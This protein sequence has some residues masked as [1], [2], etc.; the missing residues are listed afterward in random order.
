MT[1]RCSVSGVSPTLA[2]CH[3]GYAYQGRGIIGGHN[4]AAYNLEQHEA[5]CLN[6]QARKESRRVI[7]VWKNAG[8][9]PP[10][11]GQFPLPYVEGVQEVVE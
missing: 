4:F 9:E 8:L 2:C 7:R 3:C 5:S 1:K 10:I 11:P 6:Q